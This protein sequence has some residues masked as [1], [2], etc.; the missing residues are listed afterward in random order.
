[1]TAGA[2]S[3]GKKAESQEPRAEDRENRLLA[4][5]SRLSTLGSRLWVS[6]H[7]PAQRPARS[8]EGRGFSIWKESTTLPEPSQAR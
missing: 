2:A 3:L 8:A 7:P 6:P 1:M 5:D 4:L